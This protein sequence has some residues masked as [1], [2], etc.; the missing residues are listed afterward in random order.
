MTVITGRRAYDSP[1]I[2]FARRELWHGIEIIRLATMGLGKD[3][4]WTRSV[5]IAIFL[6][7]CA[8][9]LLRLPRPDVVVALTSP[10]LIS[11]LGAWFARL[12]GSRFV[13]WVMDLNPDEA[14]AAGWLRPGSPAGRLLESMSAFS[15][16]RADTIMALDHFMGSRILAK[17]VPPERVVV[18]PPWSHDEQVVFD[19][20]GR[21]RFR[22]QHG[23]SGKFVVM[24]SGNHSPCHPLDTLLE[25][26]RQVASDSTLAFCFIGGGSQWRKMQKTRLPPNVLLLPYQP[27]NAL[28]A[29]LSA[30]DLHVV[31][32]GT[33]FVGLVHPCKIYNILRVGAPVLYLGPRPSHISETLEAAAGEL[34]FA[35]AS[36][37]DPGAVVRQIQTLRRTRVETTRRI[38]PQLTEGFSRGTLL[39]RLLAEIEGRHPEVRPAG[40]ACVTSVPVPVTPGSNSGPVPAEMT[41]PRPS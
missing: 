27:L 34:P 18:I 9:R 26:A 15:F 3:G 2:R 40:Q 13:Y 20:I 24:Y 7:L 17:G 41:R 35:T 30:A 4:R 32:M 10:P 6:V 19:P 29:S 12:R 37:G 33:D 21:D 23:L 38:A 25:A 8:C 36:H 16:Q 39:P 28:S 11:F 1:G 5:D 22:K 14:I 31:V